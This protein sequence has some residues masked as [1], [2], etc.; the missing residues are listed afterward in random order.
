MD[1]APDD[2]TAR[3]AGVAEASAAPTAPRVAT[4][5]SKPAGP[6]RPRSPACIASS[7]RFLQY[8]DLDVAGVLRFCL[9]WNLGRPEQ[10]DVGCWRV[11]LATGT[12]VGEVGVWFAAA[13]P[14][15][16][17]AGGP[18]L[19]TGAVTAHWRDGSLE[20]CR[21]SACRQLPFQQPPGAYDEDVA[22]DRGGQLAVVP[23]DGAPGG[24]QRTFATVD[25]A[26]DA[27]LA[28]WRV[29]ARHDL[30]LAGFV[31]PS[32][33]VTDCDPYAGG[34]CTWDLYDPRTGARLGAVG[35]PHPLG[36]GGTAALIDDARFAA[37][38]GAHLVVQDAATAKITA[39]VEL[40]RP[41]KL[42][43]DYVVFQGAGGLLLPGPDGRVVL[44][45]PASGKIT[46][47]ILPPPC[48]PSSRP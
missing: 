28:T 44:V 29:P 37:V 12:Y 32:L 45:D 8:A 15:R 9:W 35:G 2:G 27:Q 48:P 41:A 14:L 17:G 4:W 19:G 5:S 3:A 18:S 42:R 31:G 1:A 7:D 21:A 39:S 47:T 30:A 36:A 10:P 23:L 11:D 26:T 34:A 20:V 6:E 40:P 13:Q 38:A 46:R 22:I 24:K 43:A 16:V 33:M 25:L